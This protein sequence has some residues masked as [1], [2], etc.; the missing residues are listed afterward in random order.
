MRMTIEA[1]HEARRL[2]IGAAAA[3]F[4]WFGGMAA[5]VFLVEPPALIAFGPKAQLVNAAVKADAS[6]LTMGNGFVTAR[7]DHGGLARRLYAAGAWF[8]WPALP[9]SCGRR[10]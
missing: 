3:L 7:A 5:L 1:P 2:L 4:V 6:I 8:V 10:G 9:P